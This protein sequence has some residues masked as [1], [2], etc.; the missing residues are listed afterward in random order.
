[1]KPIIPLK[2]ARRFAE[3]HAAMQVRRVRQARKRANK[4]ERKEQ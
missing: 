3:R 4:K 1:M 2:I